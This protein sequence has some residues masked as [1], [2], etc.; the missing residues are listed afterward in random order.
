MKSCSKYRKRLAWLALDALDPRQVEKLRAHLDI[1]EGCRDYFQ[2]ITQVTET[3][4]TSEA[5]SE[6]QTSEFFHCRV[7]DALRAEEAGAV[8]QGR[9]TRLQSVGLN[10]RVALPVL[11]ATAAAVLALLVFVRHP[12]VSTAP[13]PSVH[14]L[15][16]HTSKPELE[17]T[18]SNYQ[19]VANRSLEQLDELLTH[20]G[21]KGPSPAPVYTA[22]SFAH[23]QAPD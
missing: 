22:S 2:E 19:M 16:T 9:M 15:P 13:R 11:G 8:R 18:I 6:L 10:W 5:G 4:H 17:P 21:N 20:Q 7:A 12:D 23:A 14:P 3:L 1:C